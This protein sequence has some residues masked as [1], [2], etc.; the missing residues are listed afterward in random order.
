[1]ALQEQIAAAGGRFTLNPD[2]TVQDGAGTIP[3]VKVAKTGEMTLIIN[4]E[5]ITLDPSLAIFDDETG[6][7]CP[8]YELNPDGEWVE[9]KAV[10]PIREFP[11]CNFA[12]FQ[13]CPIALE[14]VQEHGRFVQSTLKEDLFNPEQLKIITQY[15]RITG[16]D[17]T[18]LIPNPETAPNYPNPETAPFLKDYAS[19]ITEI[20]GVPYVEIQVPYY[21]EGVDSSKWPVMTGLRKL[22]ELKGNWSNTIDIFQNHMNIVPWRV[23]DESITLATQFVNPATGENFTKSEISA[24]VAQMERGDFSNTNGLVLLFD[25]GK[26]SR[27]WLE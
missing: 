7:S 17:S 13:Q 23:D 9:A 14:D 5:E 24:I 15:Q 18:Q 19:G 2:G 8:G 12:E 26:S 27:G 25:V 3:G 10:T 20:N 22:P 1:M 16:P 4:G 6:F 21:V 11:T